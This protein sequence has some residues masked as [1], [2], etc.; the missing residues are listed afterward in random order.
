LFE[1]EI[2][3][4]PIV[5]SVVAQR[6]SQHCPRGAIIV[7]SVNVTKERYQQLII[8]KVCPCNQGENG[9]AATET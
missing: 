3:M 1:G 9:R 6:M 8:E 5:E 2:G 7:R 4:F